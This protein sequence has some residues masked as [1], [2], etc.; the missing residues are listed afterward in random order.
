[1]NVTFLGYDLVFEKHL[2]SL[3]SRNSFPNLTRHYRCM[4][5]GA[6][7]V[8]RFGY[9]IA[10]LYIRNSNKLV[11]FVVQVCHSFQTKILN[12]VCQSYE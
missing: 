3:E 10:L 5:N 12:E 11:V 6:N 8:A 7:T 9:F 2:M 1:M 4:L